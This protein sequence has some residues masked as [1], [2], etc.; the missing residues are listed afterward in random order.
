MTAEAKRDAAEDAAVL[1]AVAL[2]SPTTAA[3]AEDVDCSRCVNVVCAEPAAASDAGAAGAS[4]ASP[5]DEEEAARALAEHNALALA[6]D[7][8][9]AES[10]EGRL[11]SPAR[12]TELGLVPEHLTDED[13]E[14]L[15]YEYWED[16]ESARK[17]A[18]A[19]RPAP[20]ARK[21]RTATRAVGVPP[22]IGR[23]ADDPGADSASSSDDAVSAGAG[24][25]AE[26]DGSSAAGDA[27]EA[28][29]SAGA[30]I[31]ADARAS[32]G[33]PAAARASAISGDPADGSDENPF[34]GL[35]VPAGFELVQLEGEW[36]LVETGEEPEPVEL[37]I[38]TSGIKALIGSH[39][40][41]LY[42]ADLM[43]DVYARWAYLAA[44]DD[45]QVTFV[46]CVRQESRVYPRPMPLES[47]RNAPF[48]M[49][50]DAIESTW[51]AVHASGAYPDLERVVASNGDVYFYSTDYLSPVRAAALAE[52][53]AVERYQNV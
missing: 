40:Y 51:R 43:T 6:F 42:D 21:Y 3:R 28:D 13:F 33:A 20:P 1:D 2:G 7:D 24:T 34:A 9:R 45:P 39:S 23:A 53:D 50:V 52:W 36:C 31:L 30:G 4:A 11:V 8:V 35:D 44:E 19:E 48:R 47:L 26:R 41:Y 38:K 49:S 37:E 10:R 32:A 46:E 27:P 17:E 25:E 29:G 16:D 15:V 18:E 12:W 22:I 5:A 14:M